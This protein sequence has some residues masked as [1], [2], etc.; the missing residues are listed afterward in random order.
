MHPQTS[1]PLRSTAAPH[2][3]AVTSARPSARPVSATVLTHWL[4][5][6][7][8]VWAASATL[9]IQSA[10]AADM[11]AAAASALK[12]LSV[13]LPDD[14]TLPNA[15]SGPNN[16]AA[17]K[18]F[19]AYAETS[20]FPASMTVQRGE[21]I[22]AVIRRGLPGLPLRDEL[23]RQALAKANPRIFP[24]GTTYPV[25]PG[26]VLQ[27]PSIDA[28]RQLMLTQHPQAAVLFQ[29]G[30]AHSSETAAGSDKR[31]WVRFP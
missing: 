8:L 11:S 4:C 12:V 29:A 28:L 21:S 15:P 5:G 16:P 6:A 3:S 27:M 1:N 23:M 19:T 20:A 14:A 30:P 7:W 9:Y 25:R 17:A 26:T 24:K 22:D 10:Q 18:T 2:A 31:H 13:P